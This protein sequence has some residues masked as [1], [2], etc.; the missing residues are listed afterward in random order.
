MSKT[1]G[2]V[3]DPFAKSWPAPTRSATSYCLREVVFGSDGSFSPT[4]PLVARYNSDL[5]NGLRQPGEHA[6][7]P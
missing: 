2:N 6:P 4:T 7:S 5:A 3:R 1:N